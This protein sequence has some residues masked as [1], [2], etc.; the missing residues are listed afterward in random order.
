LT[1][2]ITES[3]DVN[4]AVFGTEGALDFIRCQQQST[5][6]ELVQ[7]LYRAARTFA[8]GAPQLDDITSVICKVE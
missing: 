1:D 2:G 7:G 3:E 4:G 5:P 8:G 6:G